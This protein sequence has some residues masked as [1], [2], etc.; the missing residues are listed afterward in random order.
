MNIQGQSITLTYASFMPA[1]GASA[2]TPLA[3]PATPAI[4]TGG[5]MDLLD[6]SP[7]AQSMYNRHLDATEATSGACSTCATRAYVCSSGS[8]SRPSA[9]N[10]AAYVTAHERAH[11]ADHRADAQAEGNRVLTQNIAIFSDTCAECGV[12]YVSGGEASSLIA[13]EEVAGADHAMLELMSGGCGADG[14]CCGCGCCG[15]LS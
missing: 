6:I 13:S 8:V 2:S 11:L 15:S 7:T 1:T 12:I 3:A 14:S 5:Q 4:P 9:G 10:A